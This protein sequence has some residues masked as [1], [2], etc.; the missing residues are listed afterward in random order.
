M[1]FSQWPEEDPF[2]LCGRCR[3]HTAHLPEDHPTEK[4]KRKNCQSTGGISFHQR[5]RQ[6]FHEFCP[7]VGF[8][9]LL[10]PCVNIKITQV[11]I[12]AVSSYP[13]LKTTFNRLHREVLFEGRSSFELDHCFINCI[14]SVRVVCLEERLLKSSD[15]R[16][17]FRKSVIFWLSTRHNVLIVG[18]VEVGGELHKSFPWNARGDWKVMQ[19]LIRRPVVPDF[20]E[21]IDAHQN[22]KADKGFYFIH[23]GCPSGRRSITLV[24][25]RYALL[26]IP[27]RFCHN[28]VKE[29]RSEQGQKGCCG[30][31]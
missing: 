30:I 28:V 24:C 27:I 20:R 6:L 19:L 31:T 14:F 3:K 9:R 12:L 17:Y 7:Q 2:G 1:W 21:L 10:L 15:Y 26:S 16:A 8:S 11:A 18:K 13:N 5:S 29:L 22:G 4:L 23:C 25:G